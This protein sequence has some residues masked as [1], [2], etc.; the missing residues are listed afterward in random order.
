MEEQTPFQNDYFWINPV[1]L[2]LPTFAKIFNLLMKLCKQN[3]ACF[4]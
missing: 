1:E 2:N 4:L 3:S